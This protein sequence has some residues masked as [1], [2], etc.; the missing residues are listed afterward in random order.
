[1]PGK[2]RGRT[3]MVITSEEESPT[4]RLVPAAS[5]T[6]IMR[7]FSRLKS[8]RN[9]AWA[10]GGEAAGVQRGQLPHKGG[11]AMDSLVPSA[12]L[13]SAGRPCVGVSSLLLVI[14]CCTAFH[15]F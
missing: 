5:Q 13:G 3:E 1:M 4:L 2:E 12:L 8:Q 15:G 6:R 10:G 9:A 14:G 7:S 11:I